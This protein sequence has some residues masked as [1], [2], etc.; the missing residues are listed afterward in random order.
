MQ[1][2]K[3]ILIVDDYPMNIEIMEIALAKD[4]Q[5]AMASSGEDALAT[6]TDF[7]PDLILLDVMMPG[8]DGYET[9]RRMRATP[10]LCQIKIV[11]V[12]AKA[13]AEERA[14]GFE[15]GA[16]DYITKP[17]AKKELLAKVYDYLQ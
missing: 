4:Y 17:F 10:A 14:Q 6:A 3:R 13:M 5:L 1:E 12:S 11:M 15:A 7:Q 8:M 9:C 16:D 2:Q